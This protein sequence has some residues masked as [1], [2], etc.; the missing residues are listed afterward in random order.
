M[1]K[2]KLQKFNSNHTLQTNAHVLA[3]S[4]ISDHSDM[5]HLEDKS[6]RKA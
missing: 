6:K 3:I 1:S 4:K 2:A 5:S